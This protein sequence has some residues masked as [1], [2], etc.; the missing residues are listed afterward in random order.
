MAVGL[1]ASSFRL[2]SPSAGDLYNHMKLVGQAVKIP[3]M[4]QYAP[5]Q[6]GVAIEPGVLQRL[7]NEVENIIYYKIEC[8]PVGGYITRLLQ[9]TEGRAQVLVGN[10]GYQMIEAFDRGATGAMPG[11]SMYDLYLKIYDLY[12]AGNRKEAIVVHNDLLPMLNHI[13]QGVEQ[14]IFYE[15]K[16][17]KKRGFIESD[18]CRLPSFT[19]DAHFDR[20]FEE[21]YEQVSPYL[22]QPLLV[23]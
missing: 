22:S 5:E 6:T 10:A 13:R 17:L 12:F 18:Y 2:P 15:K 14:I 3:V 20:L 21:Y 7:G 4:V 16:I 9:L 1:S 19:A 23:G 11:C 8:K